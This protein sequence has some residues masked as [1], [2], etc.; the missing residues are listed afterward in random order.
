MLFLFIAT[1]AATLGFAFVGGMHKGAY[2]VIALFVLVFILILDIER[3]ARGG[4][5]ETQAPMQN[6]IRRISERPLRPVEIPASRPEA[7]E[8]RPPTDATDPGRT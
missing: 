3:P 6:A 8:P 1:A 4:I 2:V 7:A 5:I